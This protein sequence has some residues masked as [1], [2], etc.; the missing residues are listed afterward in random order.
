MRHNLAINVAEGCKLPG[1]NVPIKDPAKLQW[2]SID[3]ERWQ[4]FVPLLFGTDEL[5]YEPLV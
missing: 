5:L 4:V 3:K 2:F 1:E